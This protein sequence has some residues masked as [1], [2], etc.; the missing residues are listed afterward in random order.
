MHNVLE[1]QIYLKC[2]IEHTYCL[3]EI[4]IIGH[5]IVFIV[6]FAK[7]GNPKWQAF[8]FVHLFLTT[9][10]SINKIPFKLCLL[11]EN[12]DLDQCGLKSASGKPFSSSLS[13]KKKAPE[14][15]L[16]QNLENYF[17]YE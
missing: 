3:S 2:Y 13:F 16:I 8:S 4:Q 6:F 10:E 1:V 12:K 7:Y 17:A 14:M 11:T 15:I 9:I 5:P